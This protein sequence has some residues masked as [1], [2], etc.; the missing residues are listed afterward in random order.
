MFGTSS[1]DKNSA[2]ILTRNTL[3]LLGNYLEQTKTNVFEIYISVKNEFKAA[4]MLNY[5]RN[6]ISHII[7]DDMLLITVIKS[8][9]N[10]LA[11]NE[12]VKLER[13]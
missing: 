9:G 1:Q 3:K 2:Q 6:G 13:I 7:F 11:H 4:M 5:Y 12:G 8:F 10:Q